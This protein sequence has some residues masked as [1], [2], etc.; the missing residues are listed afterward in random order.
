[1]KKK[2]IITGF[3]G[4]LIGT[5]A[6][7]VCVAYR[8][9]LTFLGNLRNSIFNEEKWSTYLI[10]LLTAL[11]IGYIIG[12]L[13]EYEPLSSG[14]GIP[15]IQLEIESKVSMNPLKVIVA[16]FIGGSLG[17]FLGFSLGMEGPC[18]QLG[19][20]C[21]KLISNKTKKDTETKIFVAAGAGAGIAAAFNAPLSGVLF[22]IEEMYKRITQRLL[23][24]MIIACVTADFISKQV[25]GYK[26]S[27]SQLSRFKF[28]GKSLLLFLLLGV[29][30]GVIG[31]IFNKSLLFN[32]SFF[33]K[34]KIKKRFKPMI[35]AIGATLIFIL[36]PSLLGGGHGLVE[37][38]P[39][40]NYSLQI[41]LIM[42]IIKLIYTCFCY[43]SG[44]QGGIFLP[45]LVLGALTGNIYA[46]LLNPY[47][48]EL[49]PA[50]HVLGMT[51][52][53]ASVVRAPILAVVLVFEM[54]GGAMSLL[55][56]VIVSVSS[57]VVA[58]FFESDPI[59]H[60]LKNSTEKN[61]LR[62]PDSKDLVHKG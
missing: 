4:L 51:G 6:G 28:N 55:P 48:P 30:T 33:N 18:I 22:A 57:L 1:M 12:R 10:F 54:T 21:G 26:N 20:S 61:L 38:L 34:L 32:L 43:G 40:E 50:F 3:Y 7:L 59:Y 39:K 49:A 24:I 2:A 42:L 29:I 35:A 23:V 41:L 13:L 53:L 37:N 62:S 14:S 9:C 27:F 17:S 56:L 36:M 45:I 44:A 8:Y 25:F 52:I 16:K 11:L 19:G 31:V 58:E 15:Q 60:S 46:Y 5:L 47:F